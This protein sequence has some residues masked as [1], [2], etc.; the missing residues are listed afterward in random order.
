MR[1][2]YKAAAVVVIV[3][4]LISHPALLAWGNPPPGRWEK[5]AETKPGDWMKIYT[6]DGTKH[7]HRFLSLDDDFLTCAD[8]YG[9][10]I[11]FELPQVEKIVLPKAGKYAKEWALW[12]ALGGAAITGIPFLINR[13]S[14][15][16]SEFT[17]MGEVMIASAAA[18]IGGIGGLLAGASLGAPGET[19]YISKKRAM[20]EAGE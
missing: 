18:G 5:V 1:S 7:K 16:G 2:T 12:G 17:G 19:V 20:E 8:D 10:K 3:S 6:Q 11:Q 15:G 9:E 13:A 4:I 14:G